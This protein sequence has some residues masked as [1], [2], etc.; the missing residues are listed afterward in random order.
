MGRPSKYSDD[1]LKKIVSRLCSGEPMA[2]ICRSEE[3]PSYTTVWNWIQSK[4][5]VSEAIARAREEGED[6]IAANT[7]LIARGVHPDST[8]DVQRDKL[9]IETDLK[10]L[11]KWNPKKY[12]DKVQTEH[13]GPGGGP[14]VTESIRPP[15]TREE[16]LKLNKS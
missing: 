13:S 1:I 14:I 3:M 4:K 16:W 11:A 6:V 15:I 7:R 2:Q 5:N 12:G 9:I 10:L 8:N